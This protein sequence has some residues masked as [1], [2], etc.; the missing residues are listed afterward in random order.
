MLIG[1]FERGTKSCF[2]GRGVNSFSPL[3]RTNSKTKHYLQS[4]FISVHYPKRYC[5]NSRCGAFEAELIK[6]AFLTPKRYEN[7]RHIYMKS[8]LVMEVHSYGRVE[9]KKD[10]TVGPMFRKELG[11]VRLN[12]CPIPRNN[13]VCCNNSSRNLHRTWWEGKLN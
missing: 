13:L 10:V 11:G 12:K 1:N 7:P 6:T 9:R 5:K 3:R 2:Y 4:F 8:P